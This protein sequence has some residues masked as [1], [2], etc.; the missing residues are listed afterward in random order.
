VDRSSFIFLHRRARLGFTFA[1]A[2]LHLGRASSTF[3]AMAFAAILLSWFF[4]RRVHVERV[5]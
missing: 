3:G 1:C 2:H 4:R 5:R